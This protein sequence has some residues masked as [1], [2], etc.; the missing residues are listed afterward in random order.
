MEPV[1]VRVAVDRVVEQVGADATIVEEC[2]PLARG[3]V[4]DDLLAFAA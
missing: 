2:V 4:A 3:S 1:L